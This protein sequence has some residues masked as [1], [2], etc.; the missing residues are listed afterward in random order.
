MI[1]FGLVPAAIALAK[2]VSSSAG[3]PAKALSMIGSS[4]KLEASVTTAATSSS[5]ISPL[6]CA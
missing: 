5:E 4:A 6:P 3:F 1:E 2:A